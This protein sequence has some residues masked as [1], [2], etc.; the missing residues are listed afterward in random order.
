M[1]ICYASETY[2]FHGDISVLS[3]ILFFFFCLHVVLLSRIE[4]FLRLKNDLV[5]VFYIV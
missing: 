2:D 5:L 3:P 4:L 1:F